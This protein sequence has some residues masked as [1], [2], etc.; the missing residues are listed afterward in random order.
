MSRARLCIVLVLVLSAATVANAN[1]CA[2][3]TVPAATLLFPFASF[4]YNDPISG[5]DT[6]LAIT[7]M[8]AEAQIA[9]VTLWTDYG[10]ALLNF[11]ILLTGY[12]IVRFD[13]GGILRSGYI[14]VT[15]SAP[16]TGAEG[17][18]DRGP[19]SS[20]N[21][22]HTLP[23]PSIDPPLATNTLGSRCAPDN[24]AYPGNY[25]TPISQGVLD[26][27]QSVLEVSQ[28]YPRYYSD[29]CTQPYGNLYSPDP[30]PWF[31]TRDDS[32]PS[33]MYLTVDLIQSCHLLFPD[34][35]GYFL[36]QARTDNVLVGDVMWRSMGG[37]AT[38]APAV[39]IEADTSL[40]AV[41][42]PLFVGSGLPVSFYARYAVPNN[43]V[44]DY[45][46][47]LPTAWAMRYEGIATDFISTDLLVWKGSTYNPSPIDLEI[48]GSSPLS[49]DQLVATNCLAYTY[50]AWD[51]DENVVNVPV[52]T[53]EI[54]QLPLVTQ[55]VS[56]EAFDMPADSGWVLF[57]WPSANWTSAAAGSP[58][59][60]QTWMASLTDIPGMGRMFLPGIPAANVGCFS[61]QTWPH[62]GIDYDYVG[63]DGYH[64][65]PGSVS[66]D[67]QR[68]R[69]RVD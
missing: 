61:D 40:A 7:N 52:P 53:V 59:L 15:V 5:E 20:A 68:D 42:T 16:H 66:E 67:E 57:A 64:T 9:H 46:E 21:S 19:M 11:N 58:D 28:T 25:V 62:Y 50:Y 2:F 13:I 54:N 23:P 38:A 14:P 34:S 26:F 36:D 63:P 6:L 65:S 56:A 39:H 43:G 69:D 60:W 17:V 8:S 41:A 45:R 49:P 33:W 32:G 22:L 51:E 24:P 4:D 10:V 31:Q 44:S 30:S 18:Q 48:Q 35:Q 12:D 37:G 55:R 1:I 29:D 27:I 3:D 47:P